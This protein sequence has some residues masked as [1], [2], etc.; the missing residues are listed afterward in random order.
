MKRW[1]LLPLIWLIASAAQAQ[2][3]QA[4]QEQ[5]LDNIRIFCAEQPSSTVCIGHATVNAVPQPG[6]ALERFR[7]PGDTI[8]LNSIDWLSAST[9]AKT[10]GT[11]RAIFPAYAAEDLETRAAALLALGNVALFFPPAVDLPAELVEAEVSA[12]QGANLRARPSTSAAVIARLN[13]RAKVKVAGSSPDEQWLL[14]YVNPAQR[15]WVS[16]DL[17][18]LAA[19]AALPAIETATTVPLWQ[20]GQIF[21]FR[22]GLDDAP[23]VSLQPSGLL[24]QAPEFTA[25]RYFEINGAR[26]LPSGTAWLQAQSNRGLLI[27]LI[28]GEGLVYAEQGEQT[29]EAGFQ[30]TVPLAATAAG[31]MRPAAPPSPPTAYNYEKLVRLPVQQLLYPARVSLHVYSIVAPMPADGASPLAGLGEADDCKISAGSEGANLR[32]EPDSTAPIIA[33]MAYR[34][35]AQPVARGTGRYGLFWW[36]LAEGV[37]VRGDAVAFAGACAALPLLS[38]DE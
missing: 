16:R 15:G 35:S 20:P 4:W 8:A 21:D 31:A 23:C 2:A 14:A 28:D 1:L 37:W 11:A 19:A 18:D 27:H 13:V 25:P 34:E 9:E 24:L 38:S 36:K 7:R 17:L 29:L 5:A 3:C 6:I 26:L 22:S 32:A 30:T 33:V 12:S 10:W